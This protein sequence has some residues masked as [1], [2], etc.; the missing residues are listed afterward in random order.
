[1]LNQAPRTVLNGRSAWAAYTGEIRSYAAGANH[2]VRDSTFAKLAEADAHLRRFGGIVT[3]LDLPAKAPSSA[4][5][6]ADEAYMRSWLAL[7]GIQSKLHLPDKA[8][9]Q[10]PDYAV[11][12][13]N[14]A[15]KFLNPTYHFF[16]VHHIWPETLGGP[17]EGWNVIPLPKNITSTAS[18]RSSTPS[19]GKPRPGKKSGCCEQDILPNRH[20]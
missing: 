2:I 15:A 4:L 8:Y 19:C 9:Y 5:W 11:P 17:T 6:K 18:I 7:H 1:M 20:R 16:D 12:Y 13:G 3:K 10:Y 14:E